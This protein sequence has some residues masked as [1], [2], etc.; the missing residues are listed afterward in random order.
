M[1][2]RALSLSFRSLVTETGAGTLCHATLPL[3][4]DPAEREPRVF[5]GIGFGVDGLSAR[6]AAEGEALE[7][8]TW[9]AGALWNSVRFTDAP[10]VLPEE[11]ALLLPAKWRRRLL[12]RPATVISALENGENKVCIPAAAAFFYP[13]LSHD[14]KRHSVTTGWAY[15]TDR[16]TAAAS[17]YCEVVER[18]LAML[19]WQGLLGAYLQP[20]AADTIQDWGRLCGLVGD[21]SLL[22]VM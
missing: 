2:T 14:W 9:A 6:F 20:L 1:P 16:E 10:R 17:A 3:R 4:V 18:D 15:H 19:Y 13:T 21:C 7:R 8:A 5:S 11:A 22:Q 12:E